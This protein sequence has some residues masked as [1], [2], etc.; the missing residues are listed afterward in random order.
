[1]KNLLEPVAAIIRTLPNDPG[2]RTRDD[3][4]Q[5]PPYHT[6]EAVEWLLEKRID[7]WVEKVEAS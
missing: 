3:A 1:M 5:V 7:E 6:R 2:K 4:S